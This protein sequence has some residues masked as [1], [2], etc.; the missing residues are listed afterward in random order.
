MLHFLLYSLPGFIRPHSDIFIIILIGAIGG[1]IAE[2]LVNGREYGILVTIGIGIIG[3]WLGQ[4][5]L[6]FIHINTAIPYF[7]EILRTIIGA[8]FLV[9]IFNLVTRGPK[10]EKRERDVYDWENG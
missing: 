5:Y 1:I 10:T 6:T 2:T 4:L 3:G 9:I 7:N 8:I